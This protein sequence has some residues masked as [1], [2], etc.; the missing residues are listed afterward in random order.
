M[1]KYFLFTTDVE[2]TSI[3]N[4]C[5]SDETGALVANEAIPKILD[6]YKKYNICSTFFVT[7]YF[8]E[9]FPQAVKLIYDNGHEIGCHGYS[10]QHTL[11]FDSMPLAKQIT[12]LKKAKS[13][14]ENIISDEIASFRSPALRTNRDTVNALIESGFKYDSSIASQR[15]DFFLSF[16]SK[17]KRKWLKAPRS[18]FEASKESLAKEGKSGIIEFP[19]SAFIMPYIGTTMR[20]F[21]KISKILRYFLARES[22]HK[23]KP[24]N[25][26]IHPIELIEEKAKTQNIERRHK[27][28]V[29]Y[30]FKD[31]LRHHLKLKNLGDNAVN[32]LIDQ[33]DY[34]KSKNYEFITLK[35]Y[36]SLYG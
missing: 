8:A 13:I 4:H 1:K 16:G 24:I 12:H 21:P 27:S 30:L 28:V 19:V 17:E 3:V 2:T 14:L 36:W 18:P 33:I 34:F 22:S 9:K 35:E 11:S 29:N 31:K 15:F 6:I 5:L 10:H 20:I 26:L 32:L 23:K 7:G 25:F